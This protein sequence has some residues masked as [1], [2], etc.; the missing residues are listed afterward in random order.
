MH[1]RTNVPTLIPRTA[2]AS[3]S[4]RFQDAG[5][6]SSSRSHG[7]TRTSD[8]GSTVALRVVTFASLA[9]PADVVYTSSV[10]ATPVL[11]VT[12]SVII[13][14]FLIQVGKKVTAQSSNPIAVGVHDAFSFLTS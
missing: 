1:C 12:A 11:Q 6:S 8:G 2:A 5:T 3:F 13:A 9:R 7:S 10:I 4:Q 14:L